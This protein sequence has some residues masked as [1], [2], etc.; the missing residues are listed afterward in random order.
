MIDD[1]SDSPSRLSFIGFFS[2]NRK[3]C[4]FMCY[5][6]NLFS[7]NT[8]FDYLD[9]HLAKRMDISIERMKDN[10]ATRDTVN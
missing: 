5:D 10:V 6:K 1:P 4:N 7:R 8:L 9:W 2:N 3:F